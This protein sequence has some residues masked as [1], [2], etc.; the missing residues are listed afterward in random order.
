MGGCYSEGVKCGGCVK[1][2]VKQGC[3]SVYV[4]G[5]GEG[6]LNLTVVIICHFCNYY[7]LPKYYIACIELLIIISVIIFCKIR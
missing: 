4:V 6:R 3:V 5:A 7:L 1:V 2:I